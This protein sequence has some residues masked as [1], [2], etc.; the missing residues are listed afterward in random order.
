M[1]IIISR[2]GFDW[3]NGGMPSPILPDG[4]MVSMPIPS[5]KVD[6]VKYRDLNING[7]NYY[8]IW[9]ELCPN[10]N[11]TTYCHLDP[12]IRKDIIKRNKNWVPA[13][14]Q[15]GASETHLEKYHVQV[16]DIFLFFGWFRQTELVDEKLR[17]VKGSND[18]HALYGYLQIGKITKGKDVEKY[19][20]HPHSHRDLE[21][22]NTIYEA[23]KKLMFGKEKTNLAGAGVFKFSNRVVLTKKGESRSRWDL[24]D[25]FK[26]VEISRHNKSNFKNG[27]FQSVAIG[28]EFVIS[29]NKKITKWAKN[30]I[31][32]NIDI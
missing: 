16:G 25:F 27:Y 8:K 13:F 2:K 22:N 30:I 4:T 31:L 6:V 12:D 15:I 21:S 19:K 14:G 29:E 3:A 18:I 20:W 23:S 11:H 1:K 7:F 17:Y 26:D 32:N 24:P 5:G 10:G 9:K 28:Q